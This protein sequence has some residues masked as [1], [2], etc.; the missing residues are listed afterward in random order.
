MLVVYTCNKLHN[1]PSF[2]LHFAV[3]VVVDRD[4]EF[5]ELVRGPLAAHIAAYLGARR[6][7]FESLRSVVVFVCA[8]LRPL[9]K[10]PSGA[11][12]S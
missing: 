5:S 12:V 11:D 9:R 4:D 2:V 1:L 7:C 3:V 8:R 6:A 10:A